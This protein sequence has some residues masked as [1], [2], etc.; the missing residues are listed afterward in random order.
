MF[1]SYRYTSL[2]LV[3]IIH[4]I[5]IALLASVLS[6]S[7]SFSIFLPQQF[8]DLQHLS[9]EGESLHWLL[10]SKRSHQLKQQEKK[11]ESLEEQER[12]FTCETVFVRWQTSS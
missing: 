11:V 9:K 2:L 5:P 8:F 7:S 3:S 4:E 10:C 12:P 1:L 6:S